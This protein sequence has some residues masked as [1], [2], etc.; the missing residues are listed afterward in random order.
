MKIEAYIKKV[1]DWQRGQF[2]EH[3]GTGYRN[4]LGLA[5]E[6][7]ELCHA[8]LK[9]EQGIR[10]THEEIL[11]MKKDAIGDVAVFLFAYCDSQSIS[12]VEC[13]ESVWN[14][15]QGRDWK[16]DPMNGKSTEEVEHGLD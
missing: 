11:L 16:N 2:G 7:G 5:E 4:L 9:G 10:H 6:V 3:Y 13:L 8:H 14:E 1:V 12:F 15:L